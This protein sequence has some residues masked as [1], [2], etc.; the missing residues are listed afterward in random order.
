MIN[1][2]RLFEYRRLLLAG[3][4]LL[5]L[6]VTGCASQRPADT[7]IPEHVGPEPARMAVVEIAQRMLGTPY[8]SGGQ[9]PRGFDCSGLASYSY[10][11]AGIALPRTSADQFA[12]ARPVSRGELRPGDLVFFNINGRS[13]SHVGIYVGQGRFVH[14]PGS[15]K[16]VSLESLDNPYWQRRIIGAGHYF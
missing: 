14:A 1:H 12:A 7:L 10:G 16:V 15:G 11:R 6:L 13:V 8:R 5:A 9:S 4:G 2:F 3:M